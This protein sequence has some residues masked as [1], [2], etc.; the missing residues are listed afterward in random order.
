MMERTGRWE[1]IKH[2]DYYS[3]WRIYILET[4]NSFELRI[5]WSHILIFALD[6]KVSKCQLRFST[7]LNWQKESKIIRFIF[8]PRGIKCFVP[9]K[10]FHLGYFIYFQCF[11][12]GKIYYQLQCKVSNNGWDF[13]LWPTYLHSSLDLIFPFGCNTICLL[14]VILTCIRSWLVM[15]LNWSTWR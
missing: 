2:K 13:S 4:K 3:P 9:L 11:K 5:A 8:R 6:K 15:H 10:N 1:K 14:L 12:Q 7:R